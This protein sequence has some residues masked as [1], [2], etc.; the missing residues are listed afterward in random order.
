MQER[1]PSECAAGG[2]RV[3]DSQTIFCP[4]LG[5]DIFSPP[6]VTSPVGYFLAVLLEDSGVVLSL[7]YLF[8][9][10]NPHDSFTGDLAWGQDPFLRSE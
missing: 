1:Q 9:T 5:W 8:H 10:R 6:Y 7:A 4:T 3:G 2:T